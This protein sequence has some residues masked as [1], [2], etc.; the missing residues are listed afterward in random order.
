MAVSPDDSNQ[1]E[2]YAAIC[3]SAAKTANAQMRTTFLMDGSNFGTR[4]KTL[5]KQNLAALQQSWSPF[6]PDPRR[7]LSLKLR[8]SDALLLMDF[9]L[10]SSP[11][12]D[13]S[14][15]QASLQGSE[16]VSQLT[17]SDS[18]QVIIN[19]AFTEAITRDPTAII[20]AI[21]NEIA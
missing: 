14:I 17:F 21:L 9:G 13:T 12:I 5:K 10:A 11:T 20:Q 19:D 6:V 8:D 2:K 18:L 3:L 15:A 4:L 16:I 7:G 1:V